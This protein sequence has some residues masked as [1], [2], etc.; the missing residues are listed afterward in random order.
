MNRIVRSFLF[1]ALLFTGYG[2]SAQDDLEKLLDSISPPKDTRVYAT[3]KATKLINA[4]TTETAKKGTLDFRITHRFGNAG[5]TSGGGPHTLWGWDNSEDIRFSFDYGLCDNLAIGIARNKR[6]ENLDGSIKW[7]FMNQ[8]SDNKKPLSIAL[9]SIASY[10]PVREEDFYAGVDAGVPHNFAHRMVYTSQ[11]LI[12]RKW[13][14]RLSTELIGSYNHRNFVKAYSFNGNLETNDIVSVGGALRFKL[15]KRFGI[16]MDYFHSFS[17]YR[18]GNDGYADPFGIGCEIETGGHVFTI[19]FTNASAIIENDFIPNTTDRWS[20][21]GYKFGFN[22][23][24]VFTIVK[25][26]M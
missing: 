6:Q 21:G 3:F 19:N 14:W 1:A 9:Y 22:I 11:L 10:T 20:K 8:T 16:V 12:A 15:T 26:K 24:R 18:N 2:A 5:G 7:R 23:S 25:P 4:Q 13:N 17:A